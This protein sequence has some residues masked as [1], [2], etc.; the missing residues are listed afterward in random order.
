M[1]TSGVSREYDVFIVYL[2]LSVS[3]TVA[4]SFQVIMWMLKQGRG[5][6]DTVFKINQF[7]PSKLPQY[8]DHCVSPTCVH[9]LFF[10]TLNHKNLTDVFSL[11]QNQHEMFLMRK[12]H[13]DFKAL[14][15]RLAMDKDKL[16][17]Y[18]TVSL[19]HRVVL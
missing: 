3:L 16:Q 18:I 13:L 12:N 14:A 17:D 2:P 6:I 7:F 9:L 15:Q 10:K 8:Q 4:L 19:L 1:E 5:M 11:A